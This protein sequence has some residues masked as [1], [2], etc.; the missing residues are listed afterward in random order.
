MVAVAVPLKMTVLVPM[1]QVPAALL[2]HVPLTVTVPE[3]AV[4]VP[5]PTVRFTIV[6]DPL[7]SRVIVLPDVNATVPVVMVRVVEA[8]TFNIV[9]LPTVKDSQV[10]L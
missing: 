4:N 5:V 9:A 6:I 3:P 2:S 8:A 7:V 10:V 1:V